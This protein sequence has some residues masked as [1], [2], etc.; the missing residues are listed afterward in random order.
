SGGLSRTAG[1]VFGP[2]GDFYVGSENTNEVLRYDGITGA[3]KGVFVTAG[4][5]GLARPAGIIFGGD[6]NLYVASV[7]TDSIL[8]YDGKTGAFID[9]F[10][11]PANGGTIKGP[12]GIV[13]LDTNPT[14]PKDAHRR[15]VHPGH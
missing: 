11:T 8:R 10:I 5:G 7:N 3:F 13:F 6:G 2:S 14:T 12:P 1:M 9:A 4:S 15:T